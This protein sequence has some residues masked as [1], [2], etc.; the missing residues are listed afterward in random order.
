MIKVVIAAAAVALFSSPSIA[1]TYVL[2]FGYDA[3]QFSTVQQHIGQFYYFGPLTLTAGDR[4]TF[5]F[6]AINDGE[7]DTTFVPGVGLGFNSDFFRGLFQRGKDGSIKL[8][9]RNGVEV[10]GYGGAYDCY[11]LGASKEVLSGS[12]FSV[13]AFTF[14]FNNPTPITFTRGYFGIGA[15]PEPA[16]WAMMI[17]G[18]ALTGA[19]ARRRRTIQ[20]V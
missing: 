14:N 20:V 5:R 17:G 9:D 16:A 15:I 11:C 4:V 19:T 18:F 1:E 7:I 12:N 2:D 10:A 13:A 8:F 3:S 6:T